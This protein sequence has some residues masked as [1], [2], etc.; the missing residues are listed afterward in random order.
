MK[1][2]DIIKDKEV[3]AFLEKGNENLGIPGYTDHGRMMMCRSV[4][5]DFGIKV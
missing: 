3:I 2:K 5:G 4:C 1:L